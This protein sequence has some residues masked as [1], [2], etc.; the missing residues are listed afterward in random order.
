MVDVAAGQSERPFEI[1]G[2]EDLQV[3]H[4][5]RDPGRV[6]LSSQSNLGIEFFRN[7]TW[8]FQLYENFDS[9]PPVVAP[10]N[11]LGVTTSVG[12]KF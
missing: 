4:Q 3:L 5:R 6:R 7:F 9:H 10:K 8:N 12:W 2:R 1:D 11:D